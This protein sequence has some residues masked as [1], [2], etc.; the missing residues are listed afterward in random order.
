MSDTVNSGIN[1]VLLV[2]K[3]EKLKVVS[4]ELKNKYQVKI[5]YHLLDLSDF[6]KTRQFIAQL[7]A[8][9]GLLVYNA[10]CAPVSYFENTV[11]ED[12]EKIVDVNIMAPLLLS[13]LVKLKIIE[14]RKGG[15]VLMSSFAR[16]QGSP[17]IATYVASKAF[18]AILA[19]RIWSELAKYGINVLV[20][21]AGDITTPGY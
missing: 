5:I 6:L 14:I 3:L 21:C 10:A 1:L 4:D 11:Q 12:L 19:E 2:R 16:T 18:N 15:I 17:K 20:L 7:D 13:R 9:I 8:N